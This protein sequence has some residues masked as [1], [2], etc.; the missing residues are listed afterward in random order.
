MFDM[1]FRERQARYVKQQGGQRAGAGGEAVAGLGGRRYFR[2]CWRNFVIF[3]GIT[4]GHK[5]EGWGTTQ[6]TLQ[7]CISGHVTSML[8]VCGTIC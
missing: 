1:L 3:L 7:D 4:Q 5:N 6:P 2:V 8:S